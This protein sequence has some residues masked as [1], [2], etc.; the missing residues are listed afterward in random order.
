MLP[1]H[2]VYF[3]FKYLVSMSIA[4]KNIKYQLPAFYK[5]QFV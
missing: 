5:L 1:N 2:S 4:M 3:H